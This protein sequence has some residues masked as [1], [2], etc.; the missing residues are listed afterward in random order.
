MHIAFGGGVERVGALKRLLIALLLVL[1]APAFSLAQGEQAPVQP[2]IPEL[3]DITISPSRNELVMM[4]GSV[5]TVV[6]KLIYTAV[7]G[8]AEPTRVFAYPGDWSLSRDGK[9]GFYKPG[10]IA[11]SACAWLT[12]SPIE[13]TIMPG[14]THAIRV[15]ISVPADAKPGDHLA[16]LFVEP[17]G[18]NLKAA[19][20]Q[21]QVRMKFRLAS[22]FYIMVPDLTRKPSLENLKAEAGE[23]AVV[24]TPT[25]KNQG[26]SHVRPVCSIKVVDQAG[27]IVAEMSNVELLPVLALSE[28]DIPV[29][30][31]ASLAEGVYQVRCRVDFGYGEVTEGQ[32]DL[33]I[34]SKP[35]KDANNN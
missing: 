3:D 30:V 13:E 28:I 11:N 34:R 27:V 9:M 6:V 18:D 29:T 10:T 1:V 31:D 7:S 19:Q 22:I 32:T 5:K 24:V 12:Y 35:G 14:N 23:K 15:T 21:K 17:R 8:K 26:N 33:I 25:F 4:P 2:K 20:N 16:V